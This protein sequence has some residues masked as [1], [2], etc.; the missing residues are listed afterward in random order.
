MACISQL[1]VQYA[2]AEFITTNV[3]PTDV[4]SLTAWQV[5]EKTMRMGSHKAIMFHCEALSV[6]Q[7]FF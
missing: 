2:L 6:L 1:Y 5:N 4:S 7:A 3:A